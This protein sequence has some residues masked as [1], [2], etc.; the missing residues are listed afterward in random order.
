MRLDAVLFLVGVLWL[1]TSF[2]LV[3]LYRPGSAHA[4]RPNPP[5][6]EHVAFLYVAGSDFLSR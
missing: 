4:V 3:A 2:L 6:H 5:A 1:L